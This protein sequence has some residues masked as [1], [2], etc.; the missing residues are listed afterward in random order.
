VTGPDILS[1][2]ETRELRISVFLDF[3]YLYEGS[4]EYEAGYLREYAEV[5][6]AALIAASDGDEH[7]GVRD[8]ILFS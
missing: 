2:G 6:N 8:A 5:P 1:V 7:H 4:R 3:T